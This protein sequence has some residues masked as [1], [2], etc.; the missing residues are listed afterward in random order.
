MAG[1]S[2]IA[3]PQPQAPS[4]VAEIRDTHKARKAALLEQLR[5]EGGS[6]RG[7]RN[8]LSAFSQLADDTLKALC[9]R[10]G[11]PAGVAL[12]AVGGFG[13]CELFPHS[14]VDVLLLMP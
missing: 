2:V 3:A 4:V 8:L 6:T 13:R 1:H 14:D 9:Q 11:L 10:A 7:I 5:G 12:V